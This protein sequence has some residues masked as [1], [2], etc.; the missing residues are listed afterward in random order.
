MDKAADGVRSLND[1]LF[2][3]EVF[4]C[5]ESLVMSATARRQNFCWTVFQNWSIVGMI[6]RASLSMRVAAFV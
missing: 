6:R 1:V 3:Q 5:V 2:D 4:L